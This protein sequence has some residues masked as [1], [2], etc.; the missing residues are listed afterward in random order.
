MALET[1]T[2]GL[3]TA[4]TTQT[5]VM[6]ITDEVAPTDDAAVRARIIMDYSDSGDGKSTRA[7]SFARY[8][9]QKTGKPVLLVSAEDSSKLVFQDL[10]DAGIVHPVFL[11]SSKT[12]IS[13]YEKIVEGELPD[14]IET[15]T[16]QIGKETKTQVVHKWRP[17]GKDEFSAAIFEGLST[18][19]ENILDYLRENGRFQ[20]EQSDG[21]QEGGRTFM[22]ASQTAFGFAQS[23]GL[24]LLRT[25]GMLPVERVLWTAHE[26]KGKDEFGSEVIRGPKLVGS[27]ATNTVRKLVG[28]LL[29]TDRIEGQIRCYFEN[30]PDITNPKISWKAKVTVSPL[31]A[32]AF[33]K[34]FP[35][36]YFV[37]TLP[38]DGYVGSKD[39]LIPF[40][41]FEAE[42]RSKSGDAASQLKQLFNN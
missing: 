39:G 21:F 12:T 37:P 4:D 42:V 8:Y 28:V 20:R 15:V 16:K 2:V 36:G 31:L 6:Q 34:K 30:H 17:I 22:A 41:E 14:G 23:E 29:H 9:Y 7:H 33:K 40:L 25:S 38:T 35:Q 26:S 18:I 11:T 3:P 13:T 24:K 5:N 1:K 19:T 27:A 32:N 10:I